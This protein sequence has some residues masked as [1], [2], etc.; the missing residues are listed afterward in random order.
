VKKKTCLA[1]LLLLLGGSVQAQPCASDTG[2][3]A[4]VILPESAVTNLQT[5]DI[6][7]ARDGALCVG[8]VVYN[9]GMSAA[10][11]VW[12]DD[13]QTPEVDG[14]PPGNAIEY[15]AYRPSTMMTV[16][17]ISFSYS[18]GDGIY[19]PDGIFILDLFVANGLLPVELVVFEAVVDGRDVHLR[20]TTASETN[21]VGFEVQRASSENGFHPL[22]F[23]EGHGTTLEAQ[24]YQ[25]TVFGLR[26][27]R[28][29]FR[30]KQIDFDGA[31]AYSPGVEV[32][33]EV[34]ERVFVSEAYPNPFNPQTSFT[35]AAR[36]SEDLTIQ[37]Y[38]VRG[39]L[40]QTLF[41]GRVEA[42][43]TNVFRFHAAMLKSG[44]YFIRVQGKTFL[45]TRKVMLIK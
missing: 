38:D 33:I 9:E 30:L 35:L 42:H 45:A 7:Y 13:D 34:P 32:F 10:I 16:D 26:P 44:L 29:L 23:I 15:S 27:G 6:I 17:D 1:A 36:Q 18:S 37:V 5:G 21:N 14:I 28:H 25:H 39:R 3:N 2:N 11:T 4:T 24:Q 12:G 8:E 41:S 43:E 40:V 31:F 20:W 22:S 19:T